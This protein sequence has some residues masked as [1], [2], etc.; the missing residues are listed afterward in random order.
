MAT[1]TRSKASTDSS[2]SSSNLNFVSFYDLDSSLVDTADTYSASSG[3]TKA[4]GQSKSGMFSKLMHRMR[5][6]LHH[7]T[8]SLDITGLT[9][10]SSSSATSD[11]GSNSGSLPSNA[12]SP[13][14]SNNR[15]KY[16]QS[17]SLPDVAEEIDGSALKES[18]RSSPTNAQSE[19][20]MPLAVPARLRITPP[21]PLNIATITTSPSMDNAYADDDDDITASPD[22]ARSVG[23]FGLNSNLV[24]LSSS[25]I[26]SSIKAVSM[27]YADRNLPTSGLANEVAIGTPTTT[28]AIS[29]GNRRPP[30]LYGVH[31]P[32][33]TSLSGGDFGDTFGDI[34]IL[35]TETDETPYPTLSPALYVKSA[36]Y[37]S[38]MNRTTSAS[39]ELRRIRGEGI[40]RDYW[41][42]DEFAKYC[43]KCHTLLVH[44]I[45]GLVFCYQ[46]VSNRVS[47]LIRVCDD[48]M[49][50]DEDL[51][52][53][54][55]TDT[56]LE[57][58]RNTGLLP[59]ID[60]QGSLTPFTIHDGMSPMTPVVGT[61]Q[62]KLLNT[63]SAPYSPIAPDHRST[64]HFLR[65]LSSNPAYGSTLTDAQRER[66]MRADEARELLLSETVP[67]G[68]SI[69]TADG[70]GD[71]R[72]RASEANSNNGGVASISTPLEGLHDPMIEP[73][74]S[75]KDE[76]E[77]EA[78][79]QRQ[80]LEELPAPINLERQSSNG[81]TVSR[82]GS[83][84]LR[85]N[86]RAS[87]RPG[88][89]HRLK[90]VPPED[91]LGRLPSIATH[92]GYTFP[93]ST[94]TTTVPLSPLQNADGAGYASARRLSWVGRGTGR[95]SRTPS[96]GRPH[97]YGHQATTSAASIS[98]PKAATTNTITP[99]LPPTL[100]STANNLTFGNT[101]KTASHR[102]T[103]STHWQVELSS[104][105]I[106][107]MRRVLQQLL[108]RE[109]V[110]DHKVWEDV[111]MHLLL[112][113]SHQLYVDVRAGDEINICRYV[114]VKRIPGGHPKDSHYVNG[115]VCT[116]NLVHKRMPRELIR[117]RILALTF[118]L[119]YQRSDQQF[120]SLEPVMAQERQYLEKLVHRIA[121]LQ[122][123]LVLV[124]NSVIS[125]AV[126]VR[127]SVIDSVVRCTR[128][129]VISSI[130]KLLM[131]PRTGTCGRF[132]VKTFVHDSIPGQ[133]RS[134]LFFEDCPPELGGTI[135]LRG[136][137]PQTLQRIKHITS[138]MV[139]M[140]YNLKL[141]TILLQN[142]SLFISSI[143]TTT[144]T[145]TDTR[146]PSIAAKEDEQIE[147]EEAVEEE[148]QL[149]PELDLIVSRFDEA[150][151]PYRETILSLSPFVHFPPPFLLQRVETCARE[152]MKLK[153]QQPIM[154]PPHSAS[155]QSPIPPLS[156][157][158]H[159]GANSPV[160]SATSSPTLAPTLVSDSYKNSIMSGTVEEELLLSPTSATMEFGRNEPLADY[161]SEYAYALNSFALDV[162]A[163]DLFLMDQGH[164][165]NPFFHQQLTVLYSVDCYYAET[166]CKPAY[167]CT[168]EYYNKQDYTLGQYLEQTFR[169]VGRVRVS[170]GQA[171]D[172][173]HSQ[174]GSILMWSEC[175][176][177]HQITPVLPMSEE[178]WKYSFGITSQTSI[179]PHDVYRSHIRQFRLNNFVVRFEYEDIELLE[180]VPPPPMFLKQQE[181]DHIHQ[182]TSTYWDS[183]MDRIRNF[184]YDAVSLN[185]R[186]AC[187]QELHELARKAATEKLQTLSLLRQTYD[188]SHPG[189]SI[190]LN[191]FKRE[192]QPRVMEWEKIFTS[193]AN[194]YLQPERDLKR[195]TTT[196]IR[197]L[198][199][200]RGADPGSAGDRVPNNDMVVH[201]VVLGDPDS[202]HHDIDLTIVDD[203]SRITVLPELGTTPT[204]SVL[205]TETV[206]NTAS[207]EGENSADYVLP[208]PA[209][210]S[211]TRRLSLE[212]MQDSKSGPVSTK[213]EATPSTSTSN[214]S[215]T[216]PQVIASTSKSYPSAISSSSV[217]ESINSSGK[218]KKRPPFTSTTSDAISSSLDEGFP[219]FSM[220]PSEKRH[221]DE[222]SGQLKHRPTLKA[223]TSSNRHRHNKTGKEPIVDDG[224]SDRIDSDT[225]VGK[226]VRR[227]RLD[228]SKKSKLGNDSDTSTSAER[229]RSIASRRRS[230]SFSEQPLQFK[231][232]SRKAGSQ[233]NILD[234]PNQRDKSSKERMRRRVSSSAAYGSARQLR[235]IGKST[236]HIYKNT[237]D[238]AQEDSDDELYLE[239]TAS[240]SR[241]TRPAPIME[242][243]SEQAQTVFL[244][245][246]DALD[247]SM[248]GEPGTVS[249]ILRSNKRNKNNENS[250]NDYNECGNT[251]TTGHSRVNSTDVIGFL[252]LGD[253]GELANQ[254]STGPYDPA[255]VL[256]GEAMKDNTANVA[257]KTE[258][259]SALTDTT[260]GSAITSAIANAA[261][262]SLSLAAT[263][264]RHNLKRSTSSD[265]YSIKPHHN[266]RLMN[267]RAT[268]HEGNNP[269][270]HMTGS[271]DRVS[272]VK[273]IASF[274]AAGANSGHFLPLEYP[275]APT[276][277]MLPDS[278]VH[279]RLDEPTSIIAYALRESQ[280]LV[281]PADDLSLHQ[282]DDA[283]SL[284]EKPA[285]VDIQEQLTSANE[286]HFKIQFVD[287]PFRFYCKIFYADQF[288]ALRRNCG[289][290]KDYIDSLAR[291]IKWSS[292]GGK[293][294]AAF[295]KTRDDRLI[296]KQLSRAEADALL[297][298]APSYFEYMSRA[299]FKELET[300]M[301]KL[302]GFYRI[303]Y[304]DPS[305]GE[306][307]RMDVIVMEN[308]FYNRKISRVFDLKGSVRNR[309]AEKTDQEDEVL[310][311]EDLIQFIYENPLFIREHAKALLHAAVWNDTL[312]LS[313]LNVMDYSL[314]VGIDKEKG[315]LVMGIVDFIRTFT[316][317]KRLE[318]W[319]KE[320]GLLGGGSKEPTI[321]TPFQYKKRFRN[322]MERY[323][324]MVPDKY[325]IPKVD[326]KGVPSSACPPPLVP[327]PPVPTLIGNN[328]SSSSKHL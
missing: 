138:L 86:R 107:H 201:G 233:S 326:H 28:S 72:R 284:F 267:I 188:Q 245:K 239:S 66:L 157:T 241:K 36:H 6:T 226:T 156:I 260:G 85:L 54:M 68:M 247:E 127:P 276:E 173:F 162:K 297:R 143:T 277:H 204:N 168:F 84:R 71:V 45:I 266:N 220:P 18:G 148:K 60:T 209:Q 39:R 322:A 120:L 46:C 258:M 301:A 106:S 135:V 93:N 264:P 44:S 317:D 327:Y 303:G 196:Q 51:H 78:E 182:R 65:I 293:S 56:R 16:S 77:E 69:N 197:R 132:S 160:L 70:E 149:D 250:N 314:L 261:G 34:G 100:I 134:Y 222:V 214:T 40:S 175:R 32:S 172:V 206:H 154:T 105:A 291:S 2:S 290:E 231:S 109:E 272:L 286:N 91:D 167:I 282:S 5:T 295:L 217:P 255:Q 152:L 8:G 124:Q 298:F 281:D 179:C 223:S 119:Q 27:R 115:V 95:H 292:R 235:R 10:S 230:R 128:A 268:I 257:G 224:G 171:H 96:L 101:R 294:G 76:E 67:F 174:D 170:V 203:D 73:Y 11:N 136:G 50:K 252:E 88:E 184:V 323:F 15:S 328:N 130:D 189:D 256:S 3:S 210:S 198:F 37:S 180:I 129:D 185:K 41:I 212:L 74:V 14:N 117:P 158:V 205:N 33:T 47:D 311:D 200:D 145:T 121:A 229:T 309:K 23:Y 254:A 320:T 285:P 249:T 318:S 57:T 52:N 215:G 248:R 300:V 213:E 151:K 35:S 139:F 253:E 177:C 242:D 163:A 187:R 7:A 30:S 123:T 195:A 55:N 63:T 64:D 155:I 153:Q 122:P 38:P 280:M 219:F 218:S 87:V 199:A 79:M 270:D 183:V 161:F 94:A 20:N 228:K 273:T 271:G 21:E 313:R 164:E 244:T 166:P 208:P 75:D 133:R 207:I 169:E 9:S 306:S 227:L 238:A 58:P 114:K 186:E 176:S 116:K 243:A 62:V 304:K 202:G 289:F 92:H 150:L 31:A 42:K 25:L 296:M 190:A 81:G 240:S 236:I 263:D 144:C 59:P 137:T 112:K 302:F 299:F 97:P 110:E 103:H 48:C 288:D 131:E 159:S 142:Q 17:S 4:S 19:R 246:T 113:I 193:V 269:F 13:P 90:D 118:P 99:N 315:E 259:E 283:N 319:V 237:Q 312:F 98:S 221:T 147:K 287:Q 83:M 89:I 165:P 12:R 22:S 194:R 49:P 234:V 53:S 216:A 265:A 192:L 24:N 211:L 232:G 102:R 43:Y 141:E 225:S 275:I 104:A 125:V 26:T 274:W 80:R 278:L 325:Y 251:S 108:Q 308:L 140:V 321:V 262:T 305:T 1:T 279:V 126:N 178:S 146:P 310:L 111:M 191:V 307:M 61:A 181:F 316:W 29:T 324:L 82:S